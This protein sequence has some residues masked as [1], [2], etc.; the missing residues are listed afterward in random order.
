MLEKKW[1][2]FLF[3]FQPIFATAEFLKTNFGARAVGLG[4]AYG[5]VVS[6]PSALYWNPAGLAQINGERTTVRKLEDIAKEAEAVFGEKEFSE[7][8]ENLDSEPTPQ[9]I[10]RVERG[11]EL[12]WYN[13]AALL[14][15][16]RYVGL[17]AIG[18]TAFGGSLGLGA[19]GALSQKILTTN[20]QGQSA[21]SVD[22][23]SV[24][25]LLGYAR[26]SG[27]LRWG[28]SFMGIDEGI[29]SERRNG[30][31]LNFGLQVIPIPILSAGLSVQNLVGAIQKEARN[32]QKW[33]KLDTLLRFSL[34]ITTPPPQANIRLIFGF[35]ANFD[36]PEEA[37][38]MNL[39]IAYSLN[40]FAYVMAGADHGNPAAGFGFIFRPFHLAYAVNRDT[41]FRSFQHYL[42]LNLSF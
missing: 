8:V 27:A 35:T 17:T 4:N 42:E 16:N 40:Q 20:D 34:A 9:S 1:F 39:G 6:D 37:V 24:A 13:G 10:V 36:R 41:V 14:G 38:K 11:F 5:V 21:D 29:R 15:L 33:E 32:K 31:G 12:Q 18:F 7:L 19:M 26:Q 2:Y 25:A 30:G 23:Q 3:V 22:F 28:I